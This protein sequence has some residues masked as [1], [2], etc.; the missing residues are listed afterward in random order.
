MLNMTNKTNIGIAEGK[1]L[2]CNQWKEKMI[3]FI[4]RTLTNMEGHNLKMIDKDVN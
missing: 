1:A 2:S 3:A 4:S